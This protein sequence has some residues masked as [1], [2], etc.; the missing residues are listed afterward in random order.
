MISDDDVMEHYEDPKNREPAAGPARRLSRPPRPALSE[1]VPIR[2]TAE[3]M[4]VLRQRAD[5]D[6]VTV[7]AWIRNLIGSALSRGGDEPAAVVTKA[8]EAL[9]EVRRSLETSAA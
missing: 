9:E 2:L 7:S 4:A 3:S 6:G 1:Y 5:A 8:I